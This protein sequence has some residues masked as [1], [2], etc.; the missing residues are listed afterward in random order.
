MFICV[1]FQENSERE[2]DL[3]K[4][5]SKDFFFFKARTYVGLV[6]LLVFKDKLRTILLISC[7]FF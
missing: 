2:R 6:F 7:F 4:N 5:I 1:Y 3:G